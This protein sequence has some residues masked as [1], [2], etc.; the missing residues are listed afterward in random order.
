MFLRFFRFVRPLHS[1]PSGRFDRPSNPS[2]L[3]RTCALLS[4][5]LT[6]SCYSSAKLDHD[7]ISPLQEAGHGGE[8]QLQTV[9]GKRIRVT[10]NSHFRFLRAEDDWTDSVEGRDLCVSASAVSRCSQLD[11]P[12]A[13]LAWSDVRAIEVET[14]DG[15]TTY[16][17]VVATVATVAAV[18]AVVV[19]LSGAGSA[20]KG[21]PNHAPSHGGRGALVRTDGPSEGHGAPLPLGRWPVPDLPRGPRPRGLVVVSPAS[22]PPLPD[23]AVFQFSPPPAPAEANVA[24]IA[25][26]F[27]GGERRRSAL[28]FLGAVEG[29]ADLTAEGEATVGFGAGIRI[30][31]LLELVGGAR[32]LDAGATAS[33]AF[34]TPEVPRWVGFGRLVLAFEVDSRRRFSLPIGFELGG[35]AA[36][37]YGRAVYGARVRIW[38]EMT[39]GLYPFNATYDSYAPTSRP[40][41][42][43]GILGFPTTAELSFNF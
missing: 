7:A 3:R 6:A 22:P 30:F 26:L 1:F 32:A 16:G 36:D 12:T 11:D 40:R 43:R 27:D 17:V 10:A 33:S 23:P 31:N 28:R 42:P 34:A 24:P 14:F 13:A 2:L 9:D 38:D 29:G 15:L 37:V 35:G 39:L 18:V 4:V 8:L 19:V 21:I 25:P 41:D 20:L 5:S